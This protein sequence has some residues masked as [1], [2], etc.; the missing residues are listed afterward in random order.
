MFLIDNMN[1]Q[2][3]AVIIPARIGSTRLVGKPLAK[4]GDRTMIEH[5]AL[6]VAQVGLPYIYVATDSLEVMRVLE[7]VGIKSLFVDAPCRTGSD[8]VYAASELLPKKFKYIINVQGDMPFCDPDI[9]RTL[10][11]CRLQSKADIVT[12]VV[13]VDK[14]GIQGHVSAVSD[15]NNMALYFSRHN[16]PHPF[17]QQPAAYQCHIGIYGFT[18]ESIRKFCSLGSGQLETCESLEQLRALENGMSIEL[19]TVKT[20]PLSVDTPADLEKAVAYWHLVNQQ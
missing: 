6:Q 14:D 18:D 1:I 20:V 11:E 10:V 16:I 17:V 19:C 4:I 5:V 7:D 8:R 12:P 9:V 3:V 15:V 13:L 2:D